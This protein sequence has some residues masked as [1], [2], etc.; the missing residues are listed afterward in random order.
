MVT[1]IALF[2]SADQL[3]YFVFSL[4]ITRL[5]GN[6]F[7]NSMIFGAAESVSVFLSGILMSHIRD[8]TVFFIVFV[9]CMA[10]YGVFIFVEA[11]SDILIYIAN[12][13]FVGSMGA[14]Q[15]VG[16]LIAELRVPPQS[17]GSVNMFGQVAGTGISAVA[18]IIAT[19]DGSM[20]LIV[21]ASYCIVSY[22][23]ITALLPTPGRYLPKA[24]ED[25]QLEMS[26]ESPSNKSFEKE[27]FELEKKLLE[28]AKKSPYAPLQS[29]TFH[30]MAY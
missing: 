12:C 9:M 16:F 11:P 30:K 8:T 3:Q 10:S 23:I 27:D 17:L 4:V 14:W 28:D 5:P 6:K 20:P 24:D 15:N 13:F 29:F 25:L 21:S 7:V 19:L 22:F 26:R 1:L 18:P 2:F